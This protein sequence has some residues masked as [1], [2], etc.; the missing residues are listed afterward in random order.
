MDIEVSCCGTSLDA[1]GVQKDSL[2]PGSRVST[3]QELAAWT[4]WADRVLT[5]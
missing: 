2:L 4:L 5:W 3:M 1:H